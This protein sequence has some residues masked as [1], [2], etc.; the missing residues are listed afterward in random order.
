MIWDTFQ[1]FLSAV[2]LILSNVFVNDCLMSELRFLF[3]FLSSVIPEF[4]VSY[5]PCCWISEFPKT[6][7][8]S[9]LTFWSL[10]IPEFLNSWVPLFLNSLILT[11]LVFEF[12][13]FPK[14][15]IAAFLPFWILADL[16]SS[17]PKFWPPNSCAKYFTHIC[18][19]HIQRCNCSVLLLRHC[20]EIH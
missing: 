6:W 8:A 15:W 12:L 17:F 14:L 11:L 2:G 10:A 9:F 5:I 7:I 16:N 4:L 3:E 1:L 20:A 13:N 19:L 18:F